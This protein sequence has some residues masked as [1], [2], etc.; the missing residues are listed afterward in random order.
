MHLRRMLK[1]I[2]KKNIYIGEFVSKWDSEDFT[3]CVMC[4]GGWLATDPFLSEGK[5]WIEEDGTLKA[6][7]DKFEG[8]REIFGMSEEDTDE[9]F[10]NFGYPDNNLEHK[11]F[12]ID[13]ID[14]LIFK[15]SMRKNLV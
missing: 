8:F 11:A 1:N 12:V 14:K 5:F 7:G 3:K 4:A 2:P 15:Y 9:I 10:F 13:I 6:K